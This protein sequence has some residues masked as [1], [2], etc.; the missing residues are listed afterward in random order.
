M[1]AERQE[2]RKLLRVE[3]ERD[4]LKRAAAFFA[5]RPRSGERLRPVSS[6]ERPARRS[7]CAASRSAR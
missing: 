5:G 7:P 3:Q 2:L 1:S 4:L 6:A